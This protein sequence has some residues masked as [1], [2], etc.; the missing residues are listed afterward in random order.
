[1][2]LIPVYVH[3]VINDDLHL[4]ASDKQYRASMQT[5]FS[6]NP[7]ERTLLQEICDTERLLFLA[8]STTTLC[9]SLTDTTQAILCDE[10]TEYVPEKNN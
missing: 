6:Q 9:F 4:V 5:F 1:M 2:T 10:V 8:L 3:E 7:Q